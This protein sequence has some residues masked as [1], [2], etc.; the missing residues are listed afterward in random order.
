M[1]VDPTDDLCVV[2]TDWERAEVC[3]VF[4]HQ[5]L[6][7]SDVKRPPAAAAAAAAVAVAPADAA[8]A[9]APADAVAVAAA[10]AAA[11]SHPTGGHRYPIS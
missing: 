3:A 4:L 1:C 6:H 9:V 2:I 11:A 8:V 5:R 10:A 7:G